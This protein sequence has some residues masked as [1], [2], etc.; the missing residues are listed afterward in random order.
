MNEEIKEEGSNEE[1]QTKDD[2][3]SKKA[4]TDVS[5]DMHKYKSELKDVKA[6]LNQ[7][8]A[9]K[10]AGEKERLAEQGKWEDLY[11]K[12]ELELNALKSER[13]AEQ[14]KFVNYHKKNSVLNKIG[15]FKKDE[16]NRFIQTDKINMNEDGSIDSESLGLE[17]D[18]IRQE[19]PELLKASAGN[20]LPND[21]PNG[22]TIG[23][24]SSKANDMNA[25]DKNA[26]F[27]QLLTKK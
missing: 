17:V 3:V 6:M 27:K 9:E 5:N 19:Y 25:A 7:L 22:S 8:N 26:Y 18:R 21:A 13:N 24:P 15:S 23:D 1:G 11:Q 10:S 14:D 2:F 20:K 12:N 4:Y 16:Y